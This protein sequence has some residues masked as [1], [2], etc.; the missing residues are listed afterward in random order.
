MTLDPIELNSRR[1]RIPPI[2]ISPFLKKGGRLGVS[3]GPATRS[4]RMPTRY[5]PLGDKH[6]GV[7]AVATCAT[8]SLLSILLLVLYSAWLVCHHFRR[9]ASERASTSRGIVFLTSNHG[10]FFLSLIAGDLFQAIGFSMNWTWIARGGLPSPV[11]ETCTTQ[12]IFVL[13]YTP[14]T[15]VVYGYIASV[16]TVTGIMA[17]IGPARLGSRESPFYG[18]AGGWCWIAQ[19]HQIWRL[20]LHYFWVFLVAGINL[21][22]YSFIALQIVRRRRRALSSSNKF[23][24][25]VAPTKAGANL[26]GSNCIAAIMLIYPL[27]YLLTILPISVYRFALLSG[28]TPP[29]HYALA[30][31][32]VFTLSGMINCL[33][34]A[35]TRNI[36]SFSSLRRKGSAVTGA[37]MVQFPQGGMEG[38][39]PTI[40]FR[41]P[42][43]ADFQ[44][45]LLSE[46]S[47]S[48]SGSLLGSGERGGRSVN[49]MGTSSSGSHRGENFGEL[50]GG[51]G[52]GVGARSMNE[53][54]KISMG[55]AVLESQH[56]SSG[57]TLF[58]THPS[59]GTK[60]PSPTSISHGTT[61][62]T[63]P[64][65]PAPSEM[66]LEDLSIF[67]SGYDRD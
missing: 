14:S 57:A 54:T 63:T 51:G 18:I 35:S 45:S 49:L 9:S 37:G 61:P 53:A 38:L 1:L 65:A 31:G 56:G 20:W 34:Y 66:D 43:M 36:V 4:Q 7:I 62:N 26:G 15:P 42:S 17:G 60:I 27:V 28:K 2:Y 29:I 3:S 22:A 40:S 19:S 16:W 46:T 30:G 50:S 8:L 33:V 44:A 12:A 55:E 58:H 25:T 23:G 39:G 11:N 24:T 67:E 13:S 32:C 5:L 52:V 21:I 6:A 59:G 47:G 41:R 10:I 64:P 48:V